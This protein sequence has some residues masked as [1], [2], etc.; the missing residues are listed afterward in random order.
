[1]MQEPVKSTPDKDEQNSGAPQP[2]Y[3]R[4]QGYAFDPS[5]SVQ[6]DTALIN[7]AT[8]KIPWEDLSPG[9]VGE[10][11]EVTDYDPASGCFYEPVDLDHKYLLASDGLAPSEGNPQFHQQMVYAVAMTTIKNFEKALG[12]RALWSSYREKITEGTPGE[13]PR[14]IYPREYLGRLRIY[15]HALRQANAYYS[16]SKKALLFGYFPAVSSSPGEFLPN[17][18][19]FT[20]LSHDI[21]AHETTHA[22]LDGM[23]RRFIEANHRDNLAFHEAFAD[24]VALFQHF[25]FPEVL[26]HQIAKTRGR[27]D[28]QSLLG[29]LAQQ[30]GKAIGQYGAL[31]DFIGGYEDDEKKE[32][33]LHEPKPEEYQEV[34]EPHARGAILVAAIFEAFL[35]IYKRRIADLLRI[36]TGGT[37]VLPDGEIH[38]DLVN[39]LA[40]EAAKTAQHI[41]NI[42]I[43][44]LDYCPPVDI[45]F[46]DYLRALITADIDAVPDDELGYRIA[47]IDAFKKRGIY[48]RDIRTLSE[49]SLC[50]KKFS[51]DESRKLKV[52]SEITGNMRSVVHHLDYL[53]EVPPDLFDHF[54][55]FFRAW[56][57]AGEEDWNRLGD[58]EKIHV[59][60][61]VSK[62][63]VH[64]TIVDFKFDSTDPEIREFE[65]STGL[66]LREINEKR[67]EVKG[68][69]S[70][71]EKY[72][73]EVHSLRRARRIRQDGDVLNLIVIS[74]TQHRKIPLDPAKVWD[75]LDENERE[76]EPYFK[77]RGGCTLILN[78]H[79]LS[80]RYAIVKNFGD[81]TEK[82]PDDTYKFVEENVRLARQREFRRS[83][84]NRL[85]LRAT[86]FGSRDEE[87]R[88]EPFAI[89]HNNF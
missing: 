56:G 31:R 52:L 88:Q 75:E 25:S 80:L 29:E 86:Y 72:V 4:L 69:E 21:I 49:E 6:L 59:L 81:K 79:D 36:S 89:L 1:M 50:W 48:P 74:I 57:V 27:L 63:A 41:L 60:T 82:L 73:F 87:Q 85:S 35:S 83:S 33:K 38:P 78:L 24:I 5:L 76:N 68:L 20:C 30:F 7:K 18:M 77:F 53:D 12:R 65:E 39:R 28:D 11:I 34:K 44:A 45:T 19:V 13:K 32:W 70:R 8:F 84:Q 47:L 51:K 40:D 2:V 37:G 42:C 66:Y 67:L 55:S 10:Y 26:K 43:R 71:G 46:G 62:A 64:E 15:P 22:L 9:P 17:G 61:E 16:P 3:R 23:H 14:V 58:R 54:G